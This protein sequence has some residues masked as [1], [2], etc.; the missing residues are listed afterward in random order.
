MQIPPGKILIIRFSSIGDIVLTTPVVRC[1]KLQ[2][3]ELE[4]HYLTKKQFLPVLGANPYIS[5]IWLYDH[6]FADLIPQL[7]S[8]GFDRVVDLH[9]NY[10]S[11][12]VRR[13]IGA[14]SG[15]FFK[16]NLQ[17]WLIVNFKINLLPPVHIV[18][19]YMQAVSELGIRN[20]GQG[21]DY[22]ISE[23]EIIGPEKLPEPFR[24]GFIGIVIGGKHN[25]K[26]FP[27]KKVIE[28]I[29]RLNLPVILL[30]GK[31]DRDRGEHIC[32]VAVS[33][34][35]NGC[36]YY[37][38]NQSA[39]LIRLADAVM[40][41]DTGLMHIA[42]AF[43]KKIVSVWGNTLPEFGMFPYLREE[44]KKNSLIA[45]V[46][47]LSCRPCSKLGYQVCTKKHFRCMMDTDTS[48]I[49]NFLNQ[50]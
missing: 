41:N 10:R 38:L 26:I 34:V 19:R 16:L 18:D 4:I 14:K 48:P 49:V 31:E 30:G 39:S 5:K 24:R 6:N 50:K 32:S 15:T 36:G 29:A 25:T 43:G 12:Y 40:T 28:V 7:Q 22:F 17:K 42:A 44:E 27:E 33:S 21:L 11:I 35:F 13:K 1:L 2:V 8:Q 3:P 20:D 46:K 23:D 47:G 45:E 9:K 37:S